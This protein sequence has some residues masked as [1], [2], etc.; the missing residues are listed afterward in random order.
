MAEF[1]FM[2]YVFPIKLIFPLGANEA[3]IIRAKLLKKISSEYLITHKKG[4]RYWRNKKKGAEKLG[5]KLLLDV[6]GKKWD[7][8]SKIIEKLKKEP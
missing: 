8:S 3:D 6:K 2:D 1:S 7:S 4:D 5:I